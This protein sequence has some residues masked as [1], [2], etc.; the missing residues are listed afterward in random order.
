VF[1][2]AVRPLLFD[3]RDA[4]A[5]AAASETVRAELGYRPLAGLVNN[6]GIGDPAPFLHQPLAEIREQIEVN[7]RGT[8]AAPTAT[9]RSWRGATACRADGSSS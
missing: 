8:I 4:A 6:A 5:I 3:V 7:L 1:G 2:Q 9:A